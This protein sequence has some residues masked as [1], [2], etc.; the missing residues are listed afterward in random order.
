VSQ[1]LLEFSNVVK[2][3]GETAVVNGIS[4]TVAPGEFFTLLGPSGCGKTT[5]LRL[6]AGL[7]TP[8]AGEITLA[9][10]CLAAPAR[11]IWVP[12]DKRQMGMVFQSYAI[13]PH[14]S[15]FEN[16]AFPLRVR[17]EKRAAIAKRV[18]EVLDVVGL[19]GFEERGATELSGGQ[20]QRVALAR[21]IVYTP[22]LLL[23]DEPLSNLDVKLREQMRSE[24]NGLHLRLNLALVYV[25]H[26]QAEALAM[27]DRIAVVNQGQ[28]E[29][30]GSPTEV[31]ERP[32]TR[33]V[34]DFLGR[35]VVMKGTIKKDA[36][37]LWVDVQGSG[38]VRIGADGGLS[39][40]AVVRIIS[41]PED[42]ALLGAGEAGPNEVAGRIER[43]SYLGDHLEYT[44]A[45]A[46]RSLVLP[47][48]KK[49]R[50][51]VGAEVRLAFDPARVTTLPQ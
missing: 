39:D 8:D 30:I 22:T 24:L 35:T 16:I 17:G 47:A 50:Y 33:F 7:E 38:R 18:R 44:I 23:L 25:T 36:G 14:L 43:V 37:G 19:A 27:S 48:A 20:Q 4:F 51:A 21:A 10:R 15:V 3:Y 42:I 41:R 13:W 6:L 26:D 46:G 32:R 12:T 29:Q 9:G 1:A 45:A 2:R 40:G 31:Y 28:I 34:G 49:E 11:G 5:T